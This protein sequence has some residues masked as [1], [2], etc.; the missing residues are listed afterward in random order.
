MSKRDS[1][2]G[3][4]PP[5]RSN[6]MKLSFKSLEEGEEDED[7]L[8]SMTGEFDKKVSENRRVHEENRAQGRVAE[9]RMPPKPQAGQKAKEDDK[10]SRWK[11]N[12]SEISTV[13]RKKVSAKLEDFSKELAP[14][15]DSESSTA[16]PIKQTSM[17][18][19]DLLSFVKKKEENGS[20]KFSDAQYESGPTVKETVDDFQVIDDYYHDVTVLEP[21]ED[22]TGTQSLPELRYRNRTLPQKIRRTKPNVTTGSVSLSNL[23]ANEEIVTETIENVDIQENQ[24][25]N[26][27]YQPANTSTV[28]ALNKGSGDKRKNEMS[29]VPMHNLIIGI[30]CLV[31]Y[32]ILPLPAFVSGV[33][34]G[35][36]ISSFGWKIYI[37]VTQPLPPKEKPEIVPLEQLPP[38]ILPNMKEATFADGIYK[39]W[40]NEI[41]EYDPYNHH[42]NN[43]HPVQVLLEGTTLRLRRPKTNVPRRAM[44]DEEKITVKEFIHQ[45]HFDI[46]GSNISLRPTELVSKRLWSK[47][48]P[49]RIAFATAGKRT[50][51]TDSDT[52]EQEAG[53]E[54]VTEEKCEEDVVYLFARTNRDKEDWFKRLVAAAEGSPLKNPIGQIRKFYETSKKL[55]QQSSTSSQGD[56][57][58]QKRQSSVD[59]MTHKRQGSTDSI[60]STNSSPTSEKEAI[61][62]SEHE[63]EMFV[64]YMSRLM[65]GELY[66]RFASVNSRSHPIIDCDERLLWLNA[67]ISRCFWDFLRLPTWSEKV[68]EK[69]QR[70]LNTIHIP[71]FI[72]GLNITEI[73][74]G[75]EMPVIRK[76]SRPFFDENGF[77]I[78]LAVNYG[79][80]FRMTIETKVNLMKLKD[81]VTG[82]EKFEKIKPK[83]LAIIDEE[84]EDSAES[85][86]DEEEESVGEEESGKS[87]QKFMRYLSKFTKSKYVQS[88]MDLKYVKKAMEEVSNTPVVLTVEVHFLSGELSLNIPFPPTDRLWYGFKGN[89]K[90]TL[91]AKPKVG[92]RQVTVTHITDWIEKKLSTEFQRTFVLPNMDDLIIPLFNG[93][94][95]KPED[96]NTTS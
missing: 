65:P 3:R 90:L 19:S 49:I 71:Y 9:G 62:S 23:K 43:T 34:F 88:A 93:Y 58:S 2:P 96:S 69:L 33:V 56:I 60:S 12:L 8:T 55:V 42:I 31:V 59:S 76:T 79:G 32:W 36:M 77:W 48:Y 67:L 85:S 51:S 94:S 91:V 75:N 46:R 63:M 27:L 38:F 21:A 53:F 45:R 15:P 20:E 14:D 86:T 80:G 83:K 11:Q 24:I 78:D 6:S 37:W 13:V 95:P 7:L 26:S 25:A 82:K 57:S 18:N 92:A 61:L 4:P 39:G 10:I 81:P 44:W 68:M 64:K 54:L 74:L 52:P 41:G 35:V 66:D 73:V 30:C 89:P 47:K 87:G 72:E 84:A 70:K 17:D 50:R 5:P 29:F 16:A 28:S 40:L 1:A 22:F